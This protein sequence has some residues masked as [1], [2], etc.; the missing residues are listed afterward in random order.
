MDQSPPPVEFEFIGPFSKLFR[1]L[2]KRTTGDGSGWKGR[3]GDHFFE[4]FLFLVFIGMI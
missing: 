3:W 1:G 4:V 2:I